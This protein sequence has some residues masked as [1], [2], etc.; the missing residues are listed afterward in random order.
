MFTG[1]IFEKCGTLVLPSHAPDWL[2]R[3]LLLKPHRLGLCLSCGGVSLLAAAASRRS[4]FTFCRWSSAPLATPTR[5]ASFAAALAA[6]RCSRSSLCNWSSAAPL[7]PNTSGHCL[8]DESFS[9]DEFSCRP[10]ATSLLHSCFPRCV[11]YL[12]QALWCALCDSLGLGRECNA[13]R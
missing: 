9:C 4:R 11:P 8:C 12:P 13:R 2:A 5:T 6:S 1:S 3:W 7:G 10:H